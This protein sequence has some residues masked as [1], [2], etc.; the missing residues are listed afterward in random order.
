MPEIFASFSLICG[1]LDL[2]DKFDGEDW[3]LG[4]L[5]LFSGSS[6]WVIFLGGGN[7]DSWDKDGGKEGEGEEGFSSGGTGGTT[8][9]NERIFSWDFTNFSVSVFFDSNVLLI[10]IPMMKK[11]VNIKAIINFLL[12]VKNWL[13]KKTF[14]WLF[15]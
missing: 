12:K 2:E 8:S 14:L 6:D 9:K 3:N 7:G 4:G 15:S 10:L 13:L 1:L 5:D 11:L